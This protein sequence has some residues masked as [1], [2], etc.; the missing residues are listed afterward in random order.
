MENNNP[1]PKN[2]DPK[3]YADFFIEQF[4][5]IT[6]LM[7]EMNKDYVGIR[8]DNIKQK[9]EFFQH[10][11]ILSG[12]VIGLSSIF[13]YEK[14]LNI[15]YF[16]IGFFLNL[17]FII[18]ITLYF[19]EILDKE[20]NDLLAQQD[21]YNVILDKKR[22]IIDKYLKNRLFTEKDIINYLREVESSEEAQSIKLELDKMEKE[23]NKRLSGKKEMDFSGELFV[24]LFISASF[25]I[26]LSF[27]FKEINLY[28]LFFII[29]F[30]VGLI[31]TDSI[32]FFTKYI[33]KLINIFKK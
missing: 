13:G 9:R 16:Q 28:L 24:F 21:R 10:L 32:T 31:F 15:L 25:F 14:I 26:F 11:T 2:E 6:D 3:K 5:S 7:H 1:Q 19:R 4:D 27:F 33:S 22:E 18:V 12:A 20:G 17:L 30:M 8:V 29:I 23:R